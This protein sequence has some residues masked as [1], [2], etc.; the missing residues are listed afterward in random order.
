MS[1]SWGATD[2]YSSQMSLIPHQDLKILSRII[3][4]A[5]FRFLNPYLY[6]YKQ[7]LGFES[8]ATK[9]VPSEIYV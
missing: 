4:S 2:I 7:F 9:R 6:N 1:S 8:F 5:I 3:P